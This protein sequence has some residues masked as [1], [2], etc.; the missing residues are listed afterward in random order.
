MYPPSTENLLIS[1]PA[2]PALHTL[3]EMWCLTVLSDLA[4][5]ELLLAG[6]NYTKVFYLSVSLIGLLDVGW[7]SRLE[8][9]T[10]QVVIKF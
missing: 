7:D 3:G 6:Q 10:P 4:M 5:I 9:Q 2:L 8:H 1:P